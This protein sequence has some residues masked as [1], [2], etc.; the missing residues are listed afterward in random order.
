MRPHY[1]FEDGG[2]VG[3]RGGVDGVGQRDSHRPRGGEP[4]GGGGG[5]ALGEDIGERR[6]Q[7]GYIGRVVAYGE[8]LVADRGHPKP[9]EQAS[10]LQELPED[11]RDR[12][13]IAG[14]CRLGASQSLWSLV[15]HAIVVI[16]GRWMLAEGA[17]EVRLEPSC[18]AVGTEVDRFWSEPTGNVVVLAVQKRHRLE[19]VEGHPDRDAGSRGLAARRHHPGQHPQRGPVVIGAHHAQERTLVGH[20]QATD[21]VWM[22]SRQA[23]SRP[24]H[25]CSSGRGIQIRKTHAADHDDCALLLGHLPNGHGQRAHVALRHLDDGTVASQTGRSAGRSASLKLHLERDDIGS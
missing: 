16:G 14:L 25:E 9:C 15:G 5:Q 3:V 7:A 18:M 13:Q 20:V 23:A 22:A 21:D 8:D 6:R 17:M 11:H 10:L 1:G 24:F 19:Q 12:E 4:R 2:D